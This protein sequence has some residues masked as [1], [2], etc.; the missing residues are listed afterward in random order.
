MVSSIEKVNSENLRGTNQKQKQ[1]PNPIAT[2]SL[3][4]DPTRGHWHACAG[5]ART[6]QCGLELELTLS[7]QNSFAINLLG[8]RFAQKSRSFGPDAN[9]H[10]SN[11]WFQRVP[12]IF[13]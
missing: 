13:M 1:N 3:E 2:G 5:A 12:F 6:P 11:L 8:M 10:S 7:D 9:L 4:C